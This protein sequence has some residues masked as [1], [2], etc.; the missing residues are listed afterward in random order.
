MPSVFKPL[1][2]PVSGFC[3]I[4]R[5]R[6]DEGVVLAEWVLS[7][8]IFPERRWECVT[9][10]TKAAASRHASKLRVQGERG[11]AKAAAEGCAWPIVPTFTATPAADIP[12]ALLV[13]WVIH[14]SAVAAFAKAAA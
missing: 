14:D 12:E 11:A 9:F 5:R 2:R 10:K 13:G 6:T 8:C 3:I 7:D 4:A 1:Q